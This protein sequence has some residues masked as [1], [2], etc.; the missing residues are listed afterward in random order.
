MSQLFTARN[1]FILHLGFWGAYF[2]LL[3]TIFS[4][5][6]AGERIWLRTLANGLILAGVVY[7]NLW[8]LMPR[9]Y[10]RRKFAWY[11]LSLAALIAA[12]VPIRLWVDFGLAL[13]D[14]PYRE[15]LGTFPHIISIV[16][17]ALIVV[18][19]TTMFKLAEDAYRGQRLKEEMEKHKL[20]AELQFLKAQVNPHFLFNT[21]NNIYTLSYMQHP[22]AAPMI[23]KLSEMMRYM[24]YEC[25]EDKVPLEKE[26]RYLDNY[27]SL[28][29]LKT[30][31]PQ[32]I[33]FETE[34]VNASLLIEPMFFIPFFENAFKHGDLDEGGWMRGKLLV[35]EK[36]LRFELSNSV[37]ENPGPRDAGHGVGLE[38]IRRRLELLYPKRHRLEC[39]MKNAH[40]Y[41]TLNL[42]FDPG[43]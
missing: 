6:G 40:F 15:L 39:G 24:L 5:L 23:L 38:N 18:G 21:L 4:S 17:S 31:E 11:S 14:G 2:V 13:K 41:V 9:L 20:E 37:A 30:E 10:E 29:R 22:D 1:R 19:L 27:I 8:L 7:S 36:R 35:D 25:R 32:Q 28:Q 42:E 3:Q 43:S 16:V 33:A 12:T 34:G 26:I